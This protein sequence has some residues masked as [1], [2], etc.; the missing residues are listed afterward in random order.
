MITAGM[1]FKSQS[2]QHKYD[3]S[4]VVCGKLTISLSS[5]IY[6]KLSIVYFLNCNSECQ[7]ER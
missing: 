2:R 3:L 7:S 5:I 4:L 1:S 6:E